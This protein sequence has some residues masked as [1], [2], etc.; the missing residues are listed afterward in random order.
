M[1]RAP[2]F[3]R[4]PTNRGVPDVFIA[5]L[6]ASLSF[7]GQVIMLGQAMGAAE[8]EQIHS[9]DPQ[10]AAF[11]RGLHGAGVNAFVMVP[12]VD[13]FH[14]P[15]R[16]RGLEMQLRPTSRFCVCATWS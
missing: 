3:V 6:W 10:A 1:G 15:A 4:A 12:N 11:T 14:A 7:D 5:A 13:P 8:R 2:E 9:K 16:A